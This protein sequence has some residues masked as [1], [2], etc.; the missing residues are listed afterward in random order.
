MSAAI[1][2]ALRLAEILTLCFVV[3]AIALSIGRCSGQQSAEHDW[4]AQ[5]VATV[6][7]A[8][9]AQRGETAKASARVDTVTRVVIRQ[10]ASIDRVVNVAD[11]VLAD[12]ASSTGVLR[13]TLAM[14]RTEVVIYRRTVDS[15]LVVHAEYRAH[16]DHALA[17]ADSTIAAQAAA[18]TAAKCRILGMRCPSRT[19]VALWS[20]GLTAAAI[21]VIAR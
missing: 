10:G 6:T 16:T 11:T 21:A 19:T 9:R 3:A 4:H 12:T 13:E 2:R 20:S 18:I 17:L 1:D 5:N 7:A 14:L 15:L 8:Y